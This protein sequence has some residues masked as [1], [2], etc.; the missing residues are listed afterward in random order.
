M[1]S[2]N[3]FIVFSIMTLALACGSKK[4]E[5]SKTTVFKPK[6]AQEEIAEVSNLLANRPKDVLLLKRRGNLLLQTEQYFQ[7]ANDFKWGIFYNEQDQDLFL[8]L[9]NAFKFQ[10]KVDSALFVLKLVEQ[11]LIPTNEVFLLAGEI[12]LIKRDYSK[13]IE[14]FDA[15]I[16][17]APFYAKAYYLKGLTFSE[18]KDTLRAISS[19][20]TAIE[21]DPEFLDAYNS[22][23][24]LYVGKKDFRAGLQALKSAFLLNPYDELL[25]LNLAIVFRNMSEPDSAIKYYQRAIKINPNNKEAG[26]AVAQSLIKMDKVAEAMPYLDDY[27]LVTPFYLQLKIN[28]YEKLGKVDSVKKYA[29]QLNSL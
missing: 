26:L 21:Q 19:I 27:P 2:L 5:K 25:N 24:A 20:Q 15:V 3:G 4:E 9:A 13:A 23:S 14:A 29:D 11:N 7:A 17:S 10:G 1:K 22:L 18:L 6:S 8:G 12:H 16:K 28:A